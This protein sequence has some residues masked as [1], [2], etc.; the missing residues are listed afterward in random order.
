VR[1]VELRLLSFRLSSPHVAA[2]G[3][4]TDR[5]LVVLRVVTTDGEGF[6]ECAA[7]PLPT[8]TEEFAAGAYEVIRSI[9]V[10]RLWALQRP[11][12]GPGSLV[13]AVVGQSVRALFDEVCGNKMAVAA[14]EMALV[15]SVLRSLDRSLAQDLGVSGTHVDAGAVVS[16]LDGNDRLFSQIESAL[17]DGCKRVK[18]KISPGTDLEP[19][20]QLR[21]AYPDVEL[22]ADAN[23]SY[24][25]TS[26][27]GAVRA[28]DIDVRWSKAL[29]G[30]GL[31][32]LEQPLRPG[33]LLGHRNL[34]SILIT[35]ICLDESITS[36]DAASTALAMGACSIIC[37]KPARLGGLAPTLDLHNLC[38]EAG[39]PLWCGGMLQSGLG[40]AVDAAVSGLPGFVL[41]GDLGAGAGFE[42]PD[43]FEGPAATGGRVEIHT[44]AGVGPWPDLALL[45]GVTS[46]LERLLPE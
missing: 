17:R 30:I 12:I 27:A 10:P 35:P 13:S 23:G 7:L 36:V 21:E 22:Q 5:P 6:G 11:D 33:D 43:P 20:G 3:T 40:R 31:Q 4:I 18:V 34:A 29:D 37:A 41:P 1:A 28:S 25:M 8:Y 14:I 42:E 32:L 39:I 38:L 19:L 44:G 26:R 9:L 15:D 16:A 2:H 45:G 24:T 46:R